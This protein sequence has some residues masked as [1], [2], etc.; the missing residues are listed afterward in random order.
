MLELYDT[1]VFLQNHPTYLMHSFKI[2]CNLLQSCSN[3]QNVGLI[4]FCYAMYTWN[5]CFKVE[6]CK[7]IDAIFI[8]AHE[9]C[10]FKIF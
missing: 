2:Y 7:Q 1:N 10:Q 9:K 8:Q 4:A 5:L 3:Y 6:Q